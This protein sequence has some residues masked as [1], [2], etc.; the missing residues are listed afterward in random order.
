MVVV[1][2]AALLRVLSFRDEMQFQF[3]Q[4]YFL[5]TK[6][7]SDKN[8]KLF[9]YVRSRIAQN[10]LETWRNITLQ[11]ST[12]MVPILLGIAYLNRCLVSNAVPEYDFSTAY[13]KL[14]ADYNLFEDKEELSAVVREVFSKGVVPSSYAMDLLNFAIFWYFLSG[15]LVSGFALLYYRKFRDN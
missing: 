5:I 7:M 2:A 13:S 15:F 14:G 12:Y 8:E 3:D 6:L 1:L 9:V 4:S 11:A 10:Y